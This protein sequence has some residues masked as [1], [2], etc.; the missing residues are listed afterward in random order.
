VVGAFNP[1]IQRA[2]LSGTGDGRLFAF[3]QT[4]PGS[5]IAQ[6]DKATGRVIAESPLPSI[7]QN[8]HWAFA[9]WGGDFY[10]FT[11]TR[12][13]TEVNRFR[14]ADNSVTRVTTLGASIVGAGVS[15]CAPEK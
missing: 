2:E 15:T 13:S 10:T 12:G 3:Y 6:V 11:G 9:F 1:S 7:Q 5:A 4:P 14:P 8:D